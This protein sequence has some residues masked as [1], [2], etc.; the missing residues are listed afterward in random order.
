MK[1]LIQASVDLLLLGSIFGLYSR[2]GTG[3]QLHEW[4]GVA[5]LA[6]VVVH[7]VLSW[8]RLTSQLRRL[9]FALSG[10]A[11]ANYLVNV[12]LFLALATAIG[13]GLAISLHLLPA[14]GWSVESSRF[15]HGLH[16]LASFAVLLLAALH[17]GL[18]SHA[19]RAWFKHPPG[20]ARG[21]QHAVT[22]PQSV[23]VVR[24]ALLT[25]TCIALA[26]ALLFVIS[27]VA[28]ATVAIARSVPV[29]ID[30]SAARTDRLALVALAF[31]RGL[32]V[33]AVLGGAMLIW[34]RR[35]RGRA[36]GA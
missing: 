27:L 11:L 9:P 5:V 12:L 1:R 18:S 2:R 23:R 31:G 6:A 29:A 36:T 8:P 33:L 24:P 14:L 19:V 25:L 15:W 7:V 35:G 3:P 21:A 16:G 22:R 34:R 17:V 20:A 28:G 30:T 10:A 13:S 26:W 32:L 4:I